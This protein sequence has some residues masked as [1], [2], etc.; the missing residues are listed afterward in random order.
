MQVLGRGAFKASC[1]GGYNCVLWRMLPEVRGHCWINYEW[2]INIEPMLLFS[3]RHFHRAFQSALQR[4][5]GMRQAT[6]Q[7]RRS[8]AQTQFVLII[9]MSIKT[10]NLHMRTFL[11]SYSCAA[12]CFLTHYSVLFYGV[13]IESCLAEYMPQP[14]FP[15]SDNSTEPSASPRCDTSVE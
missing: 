10:K 9:L 5:G 12:L 3:Q 14:P 4:N 1:H 8:D 11:L 13:N 7:K 2:S 15:I 6:R